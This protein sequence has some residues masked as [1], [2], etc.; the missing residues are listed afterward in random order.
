[1]QQPLRAQPV[2]YLDLDGRALRALA[3]SRALTALEPDFLPR[4]YL[5]DALAKDSERIRD[6]VECLRSNGLRGKEEIEDAMAFFLVE[7]LEDVER[8]VEGVSRDC[9]KA[10][11][12]G[13]GAEELMRIIQCSSALSDARRNK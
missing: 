2:R 9:E 5:R 13:K 10:A 3:R 8:I 11:G 7:D 1:M 12:K 4:A 6:E